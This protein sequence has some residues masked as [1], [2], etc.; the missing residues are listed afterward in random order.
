MIYQPPYPKEKNKIFISGGMTGKPDFGRAEFNAVEAYLKDKHPDAV[1]YN[2]A[3]LPI[4][5]KYETYMQISNAVIAE[6]KK[7]GD[8]IYLLPDWQESDGA[9][10]E[11]QE[12][13]AHRGI[14]RCKVCFLTDE[15]MEKIM[16][17]YSNENV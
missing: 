8:S 12:V 4:G 11:L 15:D 5:L 16:E 1:I 14:Y 3:C 10:Q 6:F 17:E 2:P 9:R 13:L 7:S